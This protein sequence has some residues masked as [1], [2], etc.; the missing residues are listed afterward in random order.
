M[1]VGSSIGAG[2]LEFDSDA[3]STGE[4]AAVRTWFDVG[5]DEALADEA[6]ES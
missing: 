1:V 2:V 5:V 3:F 6:F 4:G